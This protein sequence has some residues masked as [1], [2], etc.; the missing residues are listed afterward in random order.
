MLK[1][2]VTFRKIILTFINF[3]QI[4]EAV[5]TIYGFN[6]KKSSS[7]AYITIKLI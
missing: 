3:I 4:H 1:Q 6:F 7:T 2:V 5:M